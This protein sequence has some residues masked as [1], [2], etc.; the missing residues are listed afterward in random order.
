MERS[1]LLAAL[2]LVLFSYANAHDPQRADLDDWF[3][4]LK[5]DATPGSFCCSLSDSKRLD[6]SDWDTKDDHY[7]VRIDGQWYDVP[8]QAVVKG[9]NLVGHAL[10]WDNRSM[11]KLRCPLCNSQ[12]MTI[13]C[14]LPGTWS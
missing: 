13:R 1:F 5:S 14:F 9:K 6:D 4:G 8:A 2:L 10:V 3:K 11:D 12:Y 7:R